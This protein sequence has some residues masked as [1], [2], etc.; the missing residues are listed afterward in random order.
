MPYLSLEKQA[1][2][3]SLIEE[4]YETNYIAAKEGVHRSTI[5]RIRKRKEETGSIEYKKNPGRP[6]IISTHI[7][8]K[9]V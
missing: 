3:I 1:R 5:T 8:R 6:R 9:V 7:E 2:I 4:G